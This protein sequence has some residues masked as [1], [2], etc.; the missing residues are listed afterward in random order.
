MVGRRRRVRT[1]ELALALG[2]TLIL[3]GCGR[4][5]RSDA[6]AKGA[7][8]PVAVGA[9]PAS[10]AATDDVAGLT[11]QTPPWPCTGWARRSVTAFERAGAAARVFGTLQPGDPVAVV[12]R[13][14]AG[15]LAFSPGVAQAANVGPFRL[16]WLPPDA[17]LRLEGRCA[18]LPLRTSPKPGVCFE[19]AMGSTPIRVAPEP[20][21]TVLAVLPADGYVEVLARH[22]DGWLKVDAASGSRPGRGHGWIA[23]D[24]ANLNGPC[25][26]N[27]APGTPP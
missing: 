11:A 20:G 3:A 25:G 10:A 1:A 24:A 2:V 5:S 14:P 12:G 13:D 18:A 9:P 4:A 15:W 21:A 16:R 17:P 7:A 27:V 6:P 26:S 22:A 19:M 23:P 8:G